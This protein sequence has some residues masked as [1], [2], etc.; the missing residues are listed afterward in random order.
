MFLFLD[1]LLSNADSPMVIS[2]PT[3]T[4]CVVIDS[5]VIEDTKEIMNIDRHLDT[6]LG[7]SE[8][9]QDIYKYLRQAEVINSPI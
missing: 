1:L 9:T 6:T 4:D 7:V 2:S 8:Y 5:D 3:D